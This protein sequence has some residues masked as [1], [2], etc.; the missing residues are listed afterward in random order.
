MKDFNNKVVVITGG[1]GA[2][3]AATAAAFHRAGAGVAI[4]DLDEEKAADLGR[5]GNRLGEG[6]AHASPML[7]RRA[8]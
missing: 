4:L 2:I 5:V 3:G 8:V 6:A 1:A 7:A